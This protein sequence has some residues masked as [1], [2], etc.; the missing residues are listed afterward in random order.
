[1]NYE[2]GN[3]KLWVFA[4]GSPASIAMSAGLSNFTRSLHH[5]LTLR[6]RKPV[7][8]SCLYRIVNLLFTQFTSASA[9]T[10]FLELK[11]LSKVLG[12]LSSIV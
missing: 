5:V 4:V 9:I 3:Y 10:D 7:N 12:R 2:S 8:T 11:A 1:M 6:I